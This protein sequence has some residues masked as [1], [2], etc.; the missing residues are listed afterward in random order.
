MLELVRNYW[1]RFISKLY[2]KI[3]NDDVQIK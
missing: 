1:H 2:I 3:K